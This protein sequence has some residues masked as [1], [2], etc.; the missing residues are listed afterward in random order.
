MY[1][2]AL[3]I[4]HC[5]SEE[6]KKEEEENDTTCSSKGHCDKTRLSKTLISSFVNA[7]V[8]IDFYY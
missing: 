4:D 5:H 2:G 7:V 6:K 3:F 1:S 8:N